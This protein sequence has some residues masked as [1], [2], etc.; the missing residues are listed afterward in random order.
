MI[1][2]GYRQNMEI[3]SRNF[4]F[5]LILYDFGGTGS[6]GIG[7]ITPPSF[8]IFLVLLGLGMFLSAWFRSFSLFYHLRSICPYI[9]FGFGFRHCYSY[10]CLDA[11]CA[12]SFGI[13]QIWTLICPYHLSLTCSCIL[14]QN[15]QFFHTNNSLLPLH[16]KITTFPFDVWNCLVIPPSSFFHELLSHFI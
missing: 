9:S 2:E 11:F 7:W 10:S 3:F 4:L 12:S 8:S 5:K 16:N 14:V 15:V 1:G 6:I 13:S